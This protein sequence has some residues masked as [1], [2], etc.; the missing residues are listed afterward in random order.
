MHAVILAGGKGVRLRPYTTALPKPL[1]PIGDQHAILEIVLRQLATSGF[2]SCTI[3]IGHLGEIIRA[4]VGDGAAWGLRIDYATEESPLGTLGPLLTLREDLPE[5]FLVMNGDVLTDLDYADVLRTHRASGAPLTIATYARKVH[6]DFGVLT[7]DSSKVVAF[8]EK[9]SMD[10]RVSMGVY[11]L[12]RSTL[13]GY[14]AGLPL[15]FDELVLDLISAQNGP[16]AYE[17]DGYWLDIGRPDDY[18]RAN[19]EFTTRKSH[20]LKGA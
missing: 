4:Y 10:Y 1:V 12:S 19:A 9:P 20:L 5:T 11:G 6:I 14:T 15:G 3:A 2:T 16:H 13:E 7:T 17:F 18:D 8:T